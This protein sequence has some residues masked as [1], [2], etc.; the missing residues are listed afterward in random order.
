MCSSRANAKATASDP[1]LPPRLF[2]RPWK[3]ACRF[4]VSI[5]EVESIASSEVGLS[6]WEDEPNAWRSCNTVLVLG[7][8]VVRGVGVKKEVSP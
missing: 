3:K 8:A 6:G 4:S 1:Y 2:I 7:E 5:C